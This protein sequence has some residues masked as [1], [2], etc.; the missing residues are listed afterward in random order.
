MVDLVKRR[1]DRQRVMRLIYEAAEG[2]R[3]SQVSGQGLLDSTG[4]PDEELGDI[5]KYLESERMIKSHQTMWGHA[6]P[7]FMELTHRG[8]LEM[9]RTPPEPLPLDLALVRQVLRLFESSGEALDLPKDDAE[10]LAAEMQTIKAQ[11]NSPRPN[12]DS[13]RK[14]LDTARQILI[15]VAGTVAGGILLE[16]I[17]H[18]FQH[19]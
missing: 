9:E 1:A 8:I 10:Q 18:V 5:C 13:I 17:N 14:H 19:H 11:V 7:H 4:L 15:T 6:T 3:L 12:Q 16:A 2:S